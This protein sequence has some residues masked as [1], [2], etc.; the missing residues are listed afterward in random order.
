MGRAHA[1]LLEE[2]RRRLLDRWVHG[3]TELLNL[4]AAGGRWEEIVSLAR[5]GI[6]R[7]SLHDKFHYQLIQALLRSANR[8]KRY[9]PTASTRRSVTESSGSYIPAPQGAPRCHLT[10]TERTR[11]WHE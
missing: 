10:E 11:S 1:I 5:S 2:E 8:T 7:H 6:L 4:L 9:G 3:A